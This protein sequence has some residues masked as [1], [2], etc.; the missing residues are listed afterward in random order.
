[1]VSADALTMLQTP[2]LGVRGV[3]NPLPA[4][5]GGDPERLEDA[6]ANAPLT[7]RTLGRFV[8]RGDFEDFVRSFAGFAKAAAVTLWDGEAR[9]VHITVA[10]ENG[11]P[12]PPESDTQRNLLAALERFRD[13][14]QRVVVADYQ[15]QSFR[16]AAKVLVAAERLAE[17]VGA[18]IRETLLE[19]FGFARRE[20]GRGVTSAEV[21]AAIQ[22]VAG[23]EMVDLDL[24]VRIG[25]PPAPV[26][27]ASV[28]PATLAHWTG[29]AVAPAELLT[30]EARR[31]RLAVTS[32]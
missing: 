24:L 18:A 14:A 9:V 11:K 15:P 17:D 32:A 29:D 28:V 10:A 5:G 3:T 13:P 25:A 1:M 16:L 27:P 20:L 19:R 7:V 30:I 31:I 26:Q 12:L 22:G 4:E 8:S 23:V 6:R 2:P 21:I